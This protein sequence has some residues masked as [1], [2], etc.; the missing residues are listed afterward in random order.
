VVLEDGLDG[1]LCRVG[2]G[3][4]EVVG[5]VEQSAVSAKVEETGVME[6]A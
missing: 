5:K 3:N 2:V 4:G 1:L 6:G